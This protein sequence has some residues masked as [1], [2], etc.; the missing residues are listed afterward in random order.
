M[1]FVPFQSDEDEF[2]KLKDAVKNVEG[3][4][5]PGSDDFQDFTSYQEGGQETGFPTTTTAP[6]QGMPHSATA[7]CLADGGATKSFTPS[8]AS[9][10]YGSQA[11]SMQTLSSE[12]SSSV[13]SMSIEDTPDQEAK[14]ATRPT[15]LDKVEARNDTV[16]ANGEPEKPSLVKRVSLI[17]EDVPSNLGTPLQPF[18]PEDDADQVTV[19]E[20]EGILPSEDAAAEPAQPQTDTCEQPASEANAAEPA[21]TDNAAHDAYSQDAL[22][23]LESLGPAAEQPETPSE[24]QPAQPPVQETQKTPKSKE[25]GRSPKATRN[26]NRRSSIEKAQRRRSWHDK[27]EHTSYPEEMVSPGKPEMKIRKST[28][29]DIGRGSLKKIRSGG[30]SRGGK[31]APSP[32][33]ATYRPASMY[34]DQMVVSAEDLTTSDNSGEIACVLVLYVVSQISCKMGS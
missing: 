6:E 9:S 13:R 24:S 32:V 14:K 25:K 8:M 33:K 17:D 1:V 16:M 20:A 28:S 15:S 19:V 22:E 30:D 7:E 34:G 18:S 29:M 3:V 4:G 21:T 5:S 27:S 12:D 26:D 10:G 11:V 2:A 23:S 31:T